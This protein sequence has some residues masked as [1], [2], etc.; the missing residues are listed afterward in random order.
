LKSLSH[1]PNDLG[2]SGHNFGPRNARK[3]IKGSKDSYFRLEY[4]Q[5]LSHMFGPL[6][7]WRRHKRTTKKSKTFP[8]SNNTHRKPRT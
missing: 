7:G 6:T 2:L 3:S 5:I 1:I 8:F 4:N